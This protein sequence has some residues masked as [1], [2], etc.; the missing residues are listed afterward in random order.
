MTVT[1]PE[2]VA[3]TPSA[4]QV[5][6]GASICIVARDDNEVLTVDCNILDSIT[7]DGTKDTAGDSIKNTVT[8]ATGGGDYVCLVAVEAD[9]WMVMGY[10]GTWTAN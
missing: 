7:L 2:I 1:L 4:T 3:T 5:D 10:K 9:N 8:V 6:I